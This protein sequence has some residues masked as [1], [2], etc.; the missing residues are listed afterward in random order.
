MIRKLSVIG[1]AVMVTVWAASSAMAEITFWGGD[2]TNTIIIRPT[3]GLNIPVGGPIV[4]DQ[5]LTIGDSISIITTSDTGYVSSTSQLHRD[6]SGTIGRLVPLSSSGTVTLPG[7]SGDSVL[8][9]ITLSG[10]VLGDTQVTLYT[11]T[12]TPTPVTTTHA[13]QYVAGHDPATGRSGGLQQTT[14]G[15]YVQSGDTLDTM[16]GGINF[17]S[18]SGWNPTVMVAPTGFTQVLTADTPGANP[19]AQ[20]T[21]TN[22]TTYA[23]TSPGVAGTPLFTQGTGSGTMGFTANIVATTSQQ[24]EF[25]DLI[26]GCV[27][28]F[29]GS[30]LTVG[31]VDMTGSI[32]ASQ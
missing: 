26:A 15:I 32:R 24:Q 19:A 9:G 4:A 11:Y 7:V 20:M 13:S 25:S 3:G 5:G 27:G 17:G 10:G 8:F 28:M 12:T 23:L 22:N 18:N 2:M 31:I 29:D 14:T 16:T 30:Q 6:V 1:I 21:Q